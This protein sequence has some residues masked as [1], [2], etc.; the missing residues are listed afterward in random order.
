MSTSNKRP[1]LPCP[2]PKFFT[3][4]QWQK[5]LAR[6][7][8][9]SL[10]SQKLVVKLFTPDGSGC[11]LIASVDPTDPDIAFGLCDLGLGFPEL[12]YV[13]LQ[14]L[15]QLRGKLGLPIERDRYAT[16]EKPLR[17]YSDVACQLGHLEA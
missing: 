12:G 11:W 8:H 3:Q 15:H 14:E 6:H 7:S 1:H 16:L 17:H 4:A 9:D 13:S 10:L 5:A 2:Y